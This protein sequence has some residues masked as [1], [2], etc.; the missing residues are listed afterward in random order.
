MINIE[1]V[2]AYDWTRQLLE[3]ELKRPIPIYGFPF[4]KLTITKQGYIS[5][6]PIELVNNNSE[7]VA[8]LMAEYDKAKGQVFFK[9]TPAFLEVSWI[10][11]VLKESPDLGSF[12]FG[13]ILFKN[14]FIR[15]LYQHIPVALTGL[16]VTIGIADSMW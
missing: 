9:K 6:A 13:V 10:D 5:L 11:M 4:D 12:S 3:V 16:K 15:F 7:L 14:G 2:R 8:P 1:N